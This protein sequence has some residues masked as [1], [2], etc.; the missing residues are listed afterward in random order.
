VRD[1][2]TQYTQALGIAPLRE[3]ISDWYRSALACTVPARR[4]AITAGASAALQLACLAL[5]RRGRRGP[6]AR[7]QLPLQPAFR[8]RRR[9]H[10]GADPHHR[11]RSASSSAP[12]RCAPPGTERTR[13]V[14]LASPSNPTGTSIAPDELRRIHGVVQDAAA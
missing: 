1:G 14:L 7:P 8:E 11:R 5:D 6:D 3:R 12:T 13:G 9:G 4:I 2:A 10:G